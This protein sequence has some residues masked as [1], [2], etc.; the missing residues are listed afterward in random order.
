MNMRTFLALA[1]CTIA[2][3]FAAHASGYIPKFESKQKLKS[4]K[5][6]LALLNAAYDA[7]RKQVAP[8]T[9]AE[10]GSTHEV[11]LWT[12]TNGVQ[13]ISG[14]EARYE[15][16]IYW[17]HGR[18]RVD[19]GGDIEISHSWDGEVLHCKGKKLTSA[20]ASGYTLST[21]EPAP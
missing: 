9:V 16:R 19:L 21:F 17:H 2:F 3:P 15:G 6:C 14:S 20:G 4:H 1:L 5:A 12:P 18:K 7:H 10:D 8:K 11:T 13:I